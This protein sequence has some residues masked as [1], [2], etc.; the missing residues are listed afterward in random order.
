MNTMPPWIPAADDVGAIVRSKPPVRT[1]ANAT[2]SKSTVL[3]IASDPPYNNETLDAPGK[4]LI[5]KYYEPR[6]STVSWSIWDFFASLST[7]HGFPAAIYSDSFACWEGTC[8]FHTSPDC[9]RTCLC[10]AG[11]SHRA[12]SP[13]VEASFKI[14]AGVVTLP[15]TSSRGFRKCGTRSLRTAALH[16]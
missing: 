14:T 15:L 11:D 12:V 10:G 7:N 13:A 8:G 16:R 9:D 4:F 5:F 1:I 2:E 6:G 3:R